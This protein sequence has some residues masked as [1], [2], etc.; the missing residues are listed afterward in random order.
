MP[1]YTFICDDCGETAVLH[2]PFSVGPVSEPCDCGGTRKHDFRTDVMTQE[3]DTTNCR[4]HNVISRE[5][6]VYR[7]GTRADA[8]KKEAQYS[9]YVKQRREQLREHGN[10]GTITQS[11]A[12]PADLYHGKIRETGDKQYW[13]DKKNV[14]RHSAFKVG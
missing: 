4:D 6:R 2:R 11:H 3:V 10:R 7:P 5:K 13:N 8:D 9:Q 1:N 12:I 14:D